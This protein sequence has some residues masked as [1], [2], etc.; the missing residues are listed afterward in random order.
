MRC[1]KT[2][3]LALLAGASAPA[4]STESPAAAVPAI[5]N[6]RISPSGARILAVSAEGQR[7]VLVVTEVAT[8]ESVIA[9]RPAP[10]TQSLEGCEWVSG[11]R[12]VCTIFVYKAS[13]PPWPRERIVRLVLVDHVGS[14]PRA[15]FPNPPRKPPKLAGVI[16]QP[17]VP[18]HAPKRSSVS[19]NPRPFMD[20]E[21][22][23][24]DPMHGDPDRLLV[25]AARQATPYRTVYVV[26]A[27][28]GDA[29][30]QV[31]WQS[32]IIFWHA[33]QNGA[34]RAGTGW[35]EY[36]H[37][38]PRMWGRAPNEP[39]IG[40][41]AVLLGEEGWRR[42]DTAPLTGPH[43]EWPAEPPRV[44]G[45]SADSKHVYYQANVNAADRSAVWEASA[46][47]FAPSRRVVSDAARDVSARIISGRECGVLGFMHP[48]PGRPF[49]WLNGAFADDVHRASDQVAGQVV[50]VTSISADCDLVTLAATDHRSQRSFHLLERST[51]LIRGL[52]EQYPA[53]NGELTVRREVRWKTRDGTSLPMS[54]TTPSEGSSDSLLVLLHGSASDDSLAPLDLWPHYFAS[55]GYT[56][57]E[58]AFRGAMGFGNAIHLAG[59]RQYGQKMLDDIEDAVAWVA[60]QQ[61]LD[62][63]RVCF[64]GRGRGGHFAVTAALS[65][66]AARG[67]DERCAAFAAIDTRHTV[68]T[69]SGP[70]EPILC[71]NR[72]A[73]GGWERWAA[74]QFIRRQRV[75]LS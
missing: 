23:V 73:C 17:D 33:D 48:L 18:P 61:V 68:R 42:L 20:L 44:L 30:R 63:K 58:P 54:V 5:D 65:R 28:T 43:G 15:I 35:Y 59:K 46:D 34:V 29:R 45:Y 37:G 41:T 4:F 13:G 70:F 72:I 10:K 53:A 2:I 60:N 3:L 6:V 47:T 8:G 64:L 14:N 75:K 27:H 38:L 1:G 69:R 21:H 40:P 71:S 32:G 26:D 12:I 31:G 56:V 66:R 57:A 74:P 52:G 22:E 7:R 39:Y 16:P 9:Y 11:T 19:R 49:T 62:P 51:G 50:A 36:G 67:T 24:V 25:A 55:R